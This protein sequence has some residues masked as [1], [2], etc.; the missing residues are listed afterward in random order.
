MN[1]GL[2]DLTNY[3]P[4]IYKIEFKT[5][6]GPADTGLIYLLA[7]V[8]LQSQDN[9]ELM[10]SFFC[11]NSNFTPAVLNSPFCVPLLHS[12]WQD[13]AFPQEDEMRERVQHQ[14]QHKASVWAGTVAS[15]QIQC[16]STSA[17]RHFELQTLSNV[18]LVAGI[19]PSV[20][21]AKSNVNFFFEQRC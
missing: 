11:Q 1:G 15:F 2:K 12:L 8:L 19:N 6:Q 5:F 10:L 4:N 7:V 17:S 3:V 20:G 9:D 18:K 21:A 13:Y 14:Q 16:A